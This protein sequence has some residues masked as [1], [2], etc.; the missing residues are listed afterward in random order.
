ME[1]REPPKL[2]HFSLKVVDRCPLR[3]TCS[4]QQTFVRHETLADPPSVCLVPCFAVWTHVASQQSYGSIS[5]ISLYGLVRTL[6]D[7]RTP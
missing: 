6:M 3:Q 5:P 2:H 1:L 7:K 4:L